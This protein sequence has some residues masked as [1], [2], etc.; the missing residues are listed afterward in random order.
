MGSAGARLDCRTPTGFRHPAAGYPSRRA[1]LLRACAASGFGPRWFRCDNR[2]QDSAAPSRA[3]EGERSNR[4]G[5]PVIFL[6]QFRSL[7]GAISHAPEVFSAEWF[8][9][10]RLPH[11]GF[12]GLMQ[13]PGMRTIGPRARCP[14]VSETQQHGGD[15]M[16]VLSRKKN[17]SIVING[18]EIEITVVDIRGDKVRLA[19]DAPTSIPV[20]RREV[21]EAI[22]RGKQRGEN[23]P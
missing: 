10:V 23:T 17:E 9:R 14:G 7:R 13:E 20:H 22:E 18:T 2:T 11:G 3:V 16:L 1:G 21:Y 6:P 15:S 5:V 4:D 8:S 12:P 19:I